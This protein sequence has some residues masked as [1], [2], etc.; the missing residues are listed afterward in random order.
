M[1]TEQALHTAQNLVFGEVRVL[2]DIALEWRPWRYLT[3]DLNT[4]LSTNRYILF[5]WHLWIAVES[6][7]IQMYRISVFL[8]IKYLNEVVRSSRGLQLGCSNLS[9]KRANR[10]IRLEIWKIYNMHSGLLYIFWLKV[11]MC[12]IKFVSSDSSKESTY[13]IVSLVH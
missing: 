5:S 10:P 1:A 4:A 11:L 6:Q 12:Y 13:S 8:I 7:I 3:A 2:L 9:Q